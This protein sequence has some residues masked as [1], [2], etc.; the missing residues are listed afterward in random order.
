MQRETQRALFE[1]V[2]NKMEKSTKQKQN[3]IEKRVSKLARLN[4]TFQERYFS[5][6]EKKEAN[7]SGYLEDALVEIENKF[8][9]TG[10]RK[11]KFI[12]EKKV[13]ATRHLE[14]I[15]ERRQKVKEEK[16]EESK[17]RLEK[18]IAKMEKVLKFN[19]DS[20]TN[21]FRNDAN[22]PPLQRKKLT[23]DLDQ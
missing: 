7:S 9:S 16:E 19:W 13:E 15:E 11:R 6:L 21:N 14:G 23:K 2:Q 4:T 18:L 3:E 8:M 10:F 20:G 5:C 17:V 22:Q 1:R 12:E